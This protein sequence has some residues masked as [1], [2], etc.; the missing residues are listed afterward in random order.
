MKKDNKTIGVVLRFWTNDFTVKHGDRTATACWEQGVMKLEANATKGIKNVNPEP[1]NCLED[2]V[3]LIKE[4]FRNQG[5]LMV[6]ANK[7]PRIMNPKRRS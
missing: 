5:I 7:R 1:F 3:P 2:I 4:L 6:S